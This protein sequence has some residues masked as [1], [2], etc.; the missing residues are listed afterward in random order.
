MLRYTDVICMQFIRK[1]TKIKLKILN[2]GKHYIAIFKPFNT[3]VVSPDFGFSEPT[4]LDL[5]RHQFGKNILPVH[6]LDRATSG[7]CLFAKTQ[8]GQCALNDLFK[9]HLVNKI[10][11]AIVE[12]S[13][14]FKKVSVNKKLKRIINSK[15]K[16]HT[17]QTISSDENGE[18]SLTNFKLLSTNNNFSLIKANPITGKMHQI[19]IHL[20]YLGFPILGDK[21]YGS[22]FSYFPNAIALHAY[23]INFFPPEGGNRN[24][25]IAQPDKYFTSLAKKHSLRQLKLNEF[26]HI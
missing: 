13:P 14:D 19:R 1:T 17:H 15:A 23:S 2:E 18:K 6:R 3:I 5:A 8:F 24:E 16:H 4:L 20:S 12:G 11:I 26:R 22:K 25:I 10:Y 21:L 9:K 7:C